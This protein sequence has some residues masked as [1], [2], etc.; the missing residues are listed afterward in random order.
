MILNILNLLNKRRALK[1]KNRHNAD[2]IAELCWVHRW[3]TEM[4]CEYMIIQIILKR[5]EVAMAHK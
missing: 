3:I 1:Y 5:K 4:Q 2:G